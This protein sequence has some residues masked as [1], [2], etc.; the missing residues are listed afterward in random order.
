M[1][2]CCPRDGNNTRY[3][4]WLFLFRVVGRDGSTLSRITPGNDDQGAVYLY[5]DGY[6]LKHCTQCGRTEP[7]WDG[8][9]GSGFGP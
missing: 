4:I 6:N 8:F 9:L 3:G 5:I 1:G 7:R 2:S